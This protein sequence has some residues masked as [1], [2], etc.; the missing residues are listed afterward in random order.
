MWNRR[1]K[2]LQTPPTPRAAEI[3]GGRLGFE[4]GTPCHEREVNLQI[5]REVGRTVRGERSK[6]EWLLPT[7]GAGL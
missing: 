3:Y 6:R 2:P 7:L 5:R 4:G 1:H